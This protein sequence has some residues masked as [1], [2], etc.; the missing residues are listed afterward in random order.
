MIF[1]GATIYTYP[2][3]GKAACEAIGQAAV[4][5]VEPVEKYE[6]VRST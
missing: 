6:C 1:I 5:I 2:M 3:P 4:S